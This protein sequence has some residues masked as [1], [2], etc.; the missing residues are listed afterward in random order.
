MLFD[1]ERC[2]V[3][4]NRLKTAKGEIDS[5]CRNAFALRYTMQPILLA[6]GVHHEQV[7]TVQ[8]QR[9]AVLFLM[10]VAQFKVP[11]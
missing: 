9:M 4:L 10:S 2:Y 8:S 7:A 11:T 6:T 3:C 1:F 5:G